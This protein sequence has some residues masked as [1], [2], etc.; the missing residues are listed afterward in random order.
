VELLTRLAAVAAL[1]LPALAAGIVPVQAETAGLTPDKI[2][3]MFCRARQAGDTSTIERLTTPA[4]LAA[5]AHAQAVS[6]AFLIASPGEKPPLGDGVPWQAHPDRADRC[7]PG[8]PV[9]DGM[10]ARI[11][12]AYDFAEQPDA[13]W[14]DT[15]VLVLT[16]TPAPDSP[17]RQSWRIDDVVFAENLGTLQEFLDA[18]ALLKF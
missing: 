7:T 14:I 5:I 4:L 10:T 2:G 13:A 8:E 15:L 18:A 3:A 17:D 1:A 12:I 16:A 11:A 6:D 9:V